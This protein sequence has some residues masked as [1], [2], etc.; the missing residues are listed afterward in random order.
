VADKIKGLE[1]QAR[2]KRLDWAIRDRIEQELKMRL[3]DK[4]QDFA[5]RAQNV[6]KA[7]EKA[8]NLYTPPSQPPPP[9]T[10]KQVGTVR[11]SYMK[12]EVLDE[13]GLGNEVTKEDIEKSLLSR[14]ML[15]EGYKIE[16]ACESAMNKSPKVN[17]PRLWYGSRV[18]VAVD[19]E[20][21][22]DE[23]NNRNIVIAVSHY[24]QSIADAIEGLMR[25]RQELGA[26][27]IILR[28]WYEL[29]TAYCP[30]ATDYVA[31]RIGGRDPGLKP[32]HEELAAM[33]SCFRPRKDERLYAFSVTKFA[34]T[35]APTAHKSALD[36]RPV[37][38][39][40]LNEVWEHLKT[41]KLT[42]RKVEMAGGKEPL[43]VFPESVIAY[44]PH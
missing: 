15:L 28:V 10:P 34:P 20:P 41:K 4:Y 38:G 18:L 17:L 29:Y 31:N 43:L 22:P 2:V 39:L 5:N 42:Y 7:Y 44:Q 9:V 1:G 33:I 11:S 26:L 19:R 21:E 14:H 32:R 13:P 37:Q 8:S 40:V 36:K 12:I 3:G 24:E 23:P 6:R 16:R 25:A 27:S 30:T 35:Y